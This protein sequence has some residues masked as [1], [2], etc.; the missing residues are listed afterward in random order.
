MS[1]GVN[2]LML[3]AAL[4]LIGPA[5]AGHEFPF[6]PS[7]YPQEITVEALDANVAAQ[8]LANGTL[9]AYAGEIG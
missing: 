3:G 9:H 8:R 6:Y 4:A 7:F 2:Y 5:H 1:L